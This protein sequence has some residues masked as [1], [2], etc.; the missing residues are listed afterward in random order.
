MLSIQY[1]SLRHTSFLSL[2]ASAGKVKPL[3]YGFWVNYIS[4]AKVLQK[5]QDYVYNLL[6]RTKSQ[7]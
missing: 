4:S 7:E 5:H 6:E 3:Q 2:F 1:K